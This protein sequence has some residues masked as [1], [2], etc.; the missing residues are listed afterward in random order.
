MDGGGCRDTLSWRRTLMRQ[1]H[2]Y[3]CLPPSPHPH[4]FLGMLA[5][6]SNASV[7]FLQLSDQFSFGKTKCKAVYF[8]A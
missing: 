1:N 6:Y 3:V 4:P 7:I 8:A 5:E 2:E